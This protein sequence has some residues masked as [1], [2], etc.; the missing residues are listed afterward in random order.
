M[1]EGTL[2]IGNTVGVAVTC[3]ESVTVSATG[4]AKP[5]L[6]LAIGLESVWAEWKTGQGPGAVQ[7]FE[8]TVAGDDLD[9]D[10]IAIQ[11]NS[12]EMPSGSSIR[13]TDASEEVAFGHASKQ[14]RRRRWT[15][16]VP[17]RRPHRPQGRRSR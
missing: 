16:C 13:T 7:R 17:R 12:L 15:G 11:A 8:Y 4:A 9:T 1:P 3:N 2:G 10:G 14:M 6:M 5:C